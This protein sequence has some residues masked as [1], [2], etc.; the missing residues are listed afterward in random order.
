[1]CMRSGLVIKTIPTVRSFSSRYHTDGSQRN[2]CVYS[3]SGSSN[4][5]PQQPQSTDGSISDV[6]DSVV[7]NSGTKPTP[8]SVNKSRSV[9]Y[10]S[11]V[12]R[13]YMMQ[14]FRDFE[15]ENLSSAQSVVDIDYRYW[16]EIDQCVDD[17]GRSVCFHIHCL[18]L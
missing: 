13:F 8:K 9:D 14:R 12:T 11:I 2:Q 1:M 16:L 17:S 5:Q 15:N 10:L 18:L 7:G 6:T 3:A 4:Q